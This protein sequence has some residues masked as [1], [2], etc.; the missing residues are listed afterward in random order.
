MAKKT[1]MKYTYKDE[2]YEDGEKVY[3][4]CPSSECKKRHVGEFIFIQEFAAFGLKNPNNPLGAPLMIP[5][6][7]EN[8]RQIG[9]SVIHIEKK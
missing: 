3:F 2:V 8:D 7:D 4:F 9:F 5:E 6:F 1:K